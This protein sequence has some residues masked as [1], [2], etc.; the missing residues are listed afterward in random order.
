[1]ARQHIS[2]GS[3]GGP[4]SISD[5]SP[6]SPASRRRR[7]GRGLPSQ[8]VQPEGAR[9]RSG[10]AY[11]CT[12][13]R[14]CDGGRNRPAL[15]RR[16]VGRPALSPS[17]GGSAFLD[18]LRAARLIYPR[19]IGSAAT[20]TRYLLPISLSSVAIAP[21]A[22]KEPKQM[23]DLLRKV[24]SPATKTLEAF[25]FT[26]IQITNDRQPATFSRFWL[27]RGTTALQLEQ[28]KSSTHPTLQHNYHCWG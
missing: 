17:Y 15:R 16:E 7:V 25:S 8:G 13:G 5:R 27:P 24:N 28:L 22:P 10:E 9:A 4:L 20:T 12:S 1:M 19:S 3:Y 11:P 6:L 26:P 21:H 23:S 2:P 18:H 14:P